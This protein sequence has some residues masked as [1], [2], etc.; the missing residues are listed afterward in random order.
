MNKHP[1]AS[2]LVFNEPV[3]FEQGKKGRKGCDVPKTLFG[4][5]DLEG[6]FGKS[7]LREDFTGFVEVSEVEAVRHFTHLSQW[8]YGVDS[9]FYPLGS[10]TMK[11][12]PKVNEAACRLEGFISIHPLQDESSVQGALQVIYELERL[13]CEIT[14]MGAAS[15]Q[16][17]AGAQG[18][19]A[20]LLIIRKHL[21]EKGDP[22]KK[23]ILPDSA[24]G[25]NPASA[26]LCD[27]T[28][29]GL[30]SGPDGLIDT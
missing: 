21:T 29:V 9:N 14:G 13:L 27:Y 12:N 4:E 1:G 6:V 23:I 16:P 11:Y 19:F 15:L 10:C 7:V 20:G 3:I 18:E 30:H 5:K 2:G 8:N 25:T 26:T 24:H 28:S 17:A 22:R